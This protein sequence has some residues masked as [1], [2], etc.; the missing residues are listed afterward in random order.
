MRRVACS[1][2]IAL[3]LAACGRS[4]DDRTVTVGE[5][6][7]GTTIAMGV[8]E[9]LT[10]A[11]TSHGDGGFSNWTIASAPDSRIVAWTGSE[12]YPPPPGAG[13][14][15]FGTDVFEF[16]A[17]AAGD[18]LGRRDRGALVVRRDAH[19]LGERCRSVEP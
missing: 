5:Q 3:A 18:H 17:V 10:V 13:V 16:Q 4:S 9:Q 6:A 14:G 19:V 8:G 15:N 1:F 7:N 2:A 12:H 11:L